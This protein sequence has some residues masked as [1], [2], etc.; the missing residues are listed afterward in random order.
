MAWD[1]GGTVA[2]GKTS[3]VW[4]KDTAVSIALYGGAPG[5]EAPT[6]ESVTAYNHFGK[7]LANKWVMI[8]ET[9]DG[10]YY[11][12]APEADQVE[13]VTSAEIVSTTVAG[14]TTSQLVFH[15]QKMWVHSVETGS[16]VNIGLAECVPTYSG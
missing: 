6:G 1:G 13:V 5:A 10:H 15:R 4:A 11:L 3:A 2:L 9:S 12:I 16:D 8:G 7:V 14:V